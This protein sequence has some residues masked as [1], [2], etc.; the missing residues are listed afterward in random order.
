MVL[1]QIHNDT[2]PF[3]TLD[4]IELMS[5]KKLLKKNTINILRY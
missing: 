5:Q 2:N 1:T 4:F 3:K